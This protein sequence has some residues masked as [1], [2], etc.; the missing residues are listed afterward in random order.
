MGKANI[1]KM[2]WGVIVTLSDGDV[3]H[4]KTKDY[5]QEADQLAWVSD[6]LGLS[7]DIPVVE[8]VDTI[9]F[10]MSES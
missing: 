10:E 5:A 9:L 7:V 1:E 3:T 4:L 6:C 8:T 2:P